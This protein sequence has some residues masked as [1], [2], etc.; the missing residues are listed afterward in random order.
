MCSHWSLK[1]LSYTVISELKPFPRNRTKAEGQGHQL[2]VGAEGGTEGFIWLASTE[3]S[4]PKVSSK[5]LSHVW[6]RSSVPLILRQILPWLWT[7]DMDLL[8]TSKVQQWDRYST[9]ER[10]QEGRNELQNPNESKTHWNK[11]H[12]YHSIICRLSSTGV[13][14]YR[15]KSEETCGSQSVT[16]T[17]WVP[18]QQVPLSIEL[19]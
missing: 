6:M 5:Y 10:M 18:W 7:R 17:M 14:A 4:K 16:S 9:D 15:Q 12:I 1:W 13:M 3:M 2:V 8:C 19:S 11:F